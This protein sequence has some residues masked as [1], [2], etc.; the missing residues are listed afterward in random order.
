MVNFVNMRV[1]FQRYFVPS[2]S[3]AMIIF[4]VCIYAKVNNDVYT[5]LRDRHRISKL[6]SFKRRYSKWATFEVQTFQCWTFKHSLIAIIH[7]AF[8]DKTIIVWS[9][10]NPLLCPKHFSVVKFFLNSGQ[11]TNGMW[12]SF[13]K[14]MPNSVKMKEFLNFG[15]QNT[16]AQLEKF[17]SVFVVNLK[18]EPHYPL[19]LAFATSHGVNKQESN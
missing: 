6:S 11:E 3:A 9:F 4:A 13:L 17:E 16:I 10:L 1:D 2:F 15:A 5:F 7:H 19:L 8:S 12:P 14:N 18:F